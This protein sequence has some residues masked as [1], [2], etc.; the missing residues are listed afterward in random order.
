MEVHIEQLQTR[1]EVGRLPVIEA[2]PLQSGADTNGFCKIIVEDNGIGLDEKYAER[3]FGVFQRLHGRDDYEGTGIGL[4]IY[5]KIAE[6][7]NGNISV[8]SPPEKG[9]T[10][11]V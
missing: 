2:D 4:S 9:A 1:V 5:R 7:H 3:I 11:I 10:F 8:K 6:R